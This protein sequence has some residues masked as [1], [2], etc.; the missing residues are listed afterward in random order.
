MLPPTHV[1][2]HLPSHSPTNP[3]SLSTP[4]QC[5]LEK[6]LQMHVYV[7]SHLDFDP[8]HLLR[9]KPFRI[10]TLSYPRGICH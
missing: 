6:S 9:E 10:K 7:D 5:D 8:V 3:L 4:D 2:T 1:S